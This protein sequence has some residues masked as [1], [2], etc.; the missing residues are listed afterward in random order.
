MI[1]T[2]SLHLQL[3]VKVQSSLLNSNKKQC[4][5][6]VG[7]TSPY[8]LQTRSSAETLWV[9]CPPLISWFGEQILDNMALVENED[10]SPLWRMEM[11]TPVETMEHML[12]NLP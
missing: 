1:S 11:L 5:D 3:E 9:Q 7:A 10:Y 6:T 4:K 2:C 8:H 12:A